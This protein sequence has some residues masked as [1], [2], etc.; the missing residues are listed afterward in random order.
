M[1]W[2]GEKVKSVA[3]IL[4]TVHVYADQQN[5]YFNHPQYS[6]SVNDDDL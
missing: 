6:N 2:L 4:N 1:M 5:I 3:D